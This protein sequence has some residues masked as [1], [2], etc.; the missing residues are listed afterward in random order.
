MVQ[1]LNEAFAERIS[2]EGHRR[3][4]CSP[5]DRKG[6]KAGSQII[7]TRAEYLKHIET[8]L[9][10]T[11]GRELPG[12]FNPM[13]VCDLFMEQC[14]LWRAITYDHIEEVSSAV[15][16]FIELT[17][18]HIADN[19]TSV[20][21]MREVFQ[22]KLDQLRQAAIAKNL[23]LLKSHTE[24]HPITY[25]HYFTENLQKIRNERRQKEVMQSIQRFF[26][27]LD[28]EPS[29]PTLETVN[30]QAL[31][32]SIMEST[33]PDMGKFA[34][35]EALDCMLAYYK[36]STCFLIRHELR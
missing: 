18:G 16:T 34:S 32:K 29:Y 30:I 26:D 28:L 19:A 5:K 35:A 7:L 15:K 1:N 8:I 4:I 22:P 6:V 25:N 3:Q 9:R 2:R 17:I 27:S 10:R 23:D 24:R 14:A 31:S 11:R 21:L 20:V 36:A 12:T 33:E 13:V